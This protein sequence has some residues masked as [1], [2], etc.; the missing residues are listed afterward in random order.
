MFGSEGRTRPPLVTAVSR[1]CSA[2]AH[3]VVTVEPAAAA[4]RP[5][6]RCQNQQTFHSN[7]SLSVH[8]IDR[9]TSGVG[10]TLVIEL[11]VICAC[12]QKSRNGSRFFLA[13][14][15]Q[16]CLPVDIIGRAPRAALQPVFAPQ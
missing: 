3:S 13:A 9:S 1:R 12:R 11:E 16:R 7:P 8:L 5:A 2:C 4:H 15:A 6:R 10:T 14:G